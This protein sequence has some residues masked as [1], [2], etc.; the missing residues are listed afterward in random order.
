MANIEQRTA[1]QDP[2]ITPVAE[3]IFAVD[4]EYVRPQQ[5]ASH[6]MVDG[7]EAAFID[8]G[9]NRSVPTLL[10]AVAAQGLAPEDV[11]YILLTHVHLDHAGGA[12]QLVRRLPQ[13]KVLVHP[14]GAAHLTDPSKLIAGTRAV[15]GDATYDRMY[16]EIL[17][18]PAA[19]VECVQDGETRELGARRLEFLH[20]PGHA[21][22][23]VCIADRA[24][25]LAFTGDIFGVSYRELDNAN[26]PFVMPTTTPTQFDPQ[27]MHAS[28][29]RVLALRPTQV[30]LTHYSRV[31]QVSRLGADL[32]ADI[33][34]YVDIARTHASDGDRERAIAA[35]IWS[36]L[37]ARLRRHG[38]DPDDAAVRE[39][40]DADVRLNAAGLVAWLSRQAA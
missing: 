24:A 35:D 5:D 6:L 30:F 18:I 11:R 4:T 2:R 7:R 19:R 27:Q 25:G 36:D 40:L 29:D 12:S 14:R 32:H 34:L 10:A 13:A 37:G 9:V 33:D 28:V 22:H 23:H 17:P 38:H 15:Y 1:S 16:G 31:E 3:G 26:G 39:L 8:T 20:T 21:L